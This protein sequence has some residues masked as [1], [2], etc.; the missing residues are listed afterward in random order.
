[1]LG[2]RARSS[3]FLQSSHNSLQQALHPSILPV[4]QAVDPC[5]SLGTEEL[6]VLPGYGVEAVLKNTEYSAMDDKSKADAAK[7]KATGTGLPP[8]PDMH[9]S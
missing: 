4:V 8:P 7:A 1:M 2:M 9:S 5:A 6:L 3:F